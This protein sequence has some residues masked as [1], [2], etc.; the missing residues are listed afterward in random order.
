MSECPCIVHHMLC[1]RSLS[2]AAPMPVVG[3]VTTVTYCLHIL[4]DS[5]RII[6]LSLPKAFVPPIAESPTADIDAAVSPLRKVATAS[7]C[8][9][10]VMFLVPLIPAF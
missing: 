1:T 8:I 6:N 5:G 4:L 10:A 7:Y 9:V 2:P 3:L